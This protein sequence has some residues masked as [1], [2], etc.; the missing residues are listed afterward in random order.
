MT[1]NSIPVRSLQLSIFA[2]TIALGIHS[3][4]ARPTYDPSIQQGFAGDVF[5][6]VS[7]IDERMFQDGIV[8]Q[9]VIDVVNADIT[10]CSSAAN[11]WGTDR[12]ASRRFIAS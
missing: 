4:S 6:D 12:Y 2:A 8:A 3:L 11:N 1:N 10:Y 7:Y 5:D 9:D